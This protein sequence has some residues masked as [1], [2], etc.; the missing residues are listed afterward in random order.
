MVVGKVVR[1]NGA[2]GVLI[3]SGFGITNGKGNRT[4]WGDFVDELE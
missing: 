3:T 2:K 1:Q 4:N